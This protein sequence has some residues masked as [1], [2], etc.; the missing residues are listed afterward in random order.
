MRNITNEASHR[1]VRRLGP[2]D[3]LPERGEEGCSCM[4]PAKDPYFS[5]FMLVW[6]RGVVDYYVRMECPIHGPKIS[7]IELTI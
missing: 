4:E 3:V 7:E 6:N 5:E 2:D 1:V